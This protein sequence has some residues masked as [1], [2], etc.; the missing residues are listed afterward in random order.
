MEVV[1]CRDCRRL[2]NF[3][4]PFEVTYPWDAM[5]DDGFCSCGERKEV[6]EDV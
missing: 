4:C 3:T 6:P 5:D 1:R 2:K